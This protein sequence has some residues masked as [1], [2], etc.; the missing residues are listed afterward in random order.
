[1]NIYR[2]M[3]KEM[4]LISRTDN[5]LRS[6]NR[7]LGAKVNRFSIMA[8]CAAR[9][10][11]L[12]RQENLHSL[13][14]KLSFWK[15][16]LYFEFRLFV[17]AVQTWVASVFISLFGA[18]TVSKSIGIDHELLELTTNKIDSLEE[19]VYSD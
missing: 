9:G 18:R 15:G 7:E 12:D 1:M 11:S 8:R 14:Q 10:A 16:Q 4:L 5:I 17:I 13:T 3:P 6:L 2:N 19:P